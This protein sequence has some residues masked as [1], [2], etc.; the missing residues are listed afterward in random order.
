MTLKFY[1]L[2]LFILLY[3]GCTNPFSTRG[4][5]DPDVNN[6]ADTYSSPTDAITVLENLKYALEE[7]NQFNYI[8]CLVDT[9]LGGTYPF[10]FIPD[11][12]IQWQKLID[13]QLVDERNYINKV[14]K[15]SSIVQFKYLTE[16][17]PQ[18]VQNSIDLAETRFFLYELKLVTD[19]E[20]TF[21][22]KA[23]MKLVKNEVSLWSIYYWED[24]RDDAE[25]PNT[26]SQLKS[27]YKN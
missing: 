13:W 4:V 1:T 14:F 15:E 8:S 21:T 11:R 5:E 22:G 24:A 19:K 12:T 3:H 20:Y 9:S 17:D 18:F 25:N 27:D 6:Q 16:P 2:L 26:W 7:K 23:R 10:I